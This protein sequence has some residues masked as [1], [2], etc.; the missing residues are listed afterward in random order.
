MKKLLLSSVVVFTLSSV[1]HAEGVFSELPGTVDT[2]LTCLAVGPKFRQGQGLSKSVFIASRLEFDLL[3]NEEK[4]Q[5]TLVSYIGHV[6]ISFD[7]YENEKPEPTF[8]NAYYGVYLGTNKQSV[9]GPRARVY[10][11]DNYYRF[12]G[13]DATTTTTMDGGGM[14]GYL[15]ISKDLTKAHYVFQSGSHMG[16]TID[17]ECK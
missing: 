16:G 6:E 14:W 4:T 8:D 10:T 5:A 1:S 9:L 13:F 7:S 12:N 3:S 2:K 15:V 17:F 11:D